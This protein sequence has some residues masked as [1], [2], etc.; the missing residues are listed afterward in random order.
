MKLTILKIIS[1]I[2]LL[3]TIALLGLSVVAIIY[4]AILVFATILILISLT[5]LLIYPYKNAHSDLINPES[6]NPKKWLKS[7]LQFKTSR[8]FFRT[9][10]LAIFAM[11]FS[12]SLMVLLKSVSWY[13]H[14]QPLDK[15]LQTF[16]DIYKEHKKGFQ[17]LPENFEDQK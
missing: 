6:T 2:N 13:F 9:I 15:E 11:I 14:I 4:P 12:F 17:P 5:C 10:L 1:W 7:R 16:R 8:R 3:F